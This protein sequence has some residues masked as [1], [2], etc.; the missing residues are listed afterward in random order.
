MKRSWKQTFHAVSELTLL[1][2]Q[3]YLGDLNLADEFLDY[4]DQR[5]GL[6]VGKGGELDHP[7]SYSFPHRTIQEYLAGCYLIVKREPVR[8]YYRHAAEGDFWSLAA[9]MGAEEIFYNRRNT[10]TLLDLAYD[11]C[12]SD[13]TARLSKMNAHYC[14]QGKLPVLLETRKF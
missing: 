1:E 3:E 4:V 10:K 8:E 12:P 9:L 7:T 2:G 11:L 5:A 14:G 13:G 6:L